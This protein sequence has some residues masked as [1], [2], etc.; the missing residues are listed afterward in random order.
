MR[1]FFICAWAALLANTNA[2]SEP[3]VQRQLILGGEI[4]PSGSKTYVVGL[5]PTVNGNSLCGG[6]LVSPTHVLTASHCVTQDI[7]W[8]SIG[9]HY[10]N[11]TQDGE[12][13]RVISIMNHPSYFSEKERYSSDFAM[14]ELEKPSRFKP[15]KLAAAD[16]SDFTAGKWT[17]TMGW[18]MDAEVNGTYSHE[19]QR[20]DL[21]LVGDQECAKQT[22]IDSTMVCAGGV[23]NRDSCY[24]DSGGPLIL[25]GGNS[26]EDVVIGVVSWGKDD[27]CG[28][29]GYPGIYS[30][31]SSV[32][33]WI[34]SI[35]EGNGTCLG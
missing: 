30:R 27:T 12:Q 2:F 13:I 5:R 25:D 11:G 17:V 31:V 32:R 3:P 22:L 16:D 15:V 4:V 14:L 21:Q 19:L 1:S 33:S 10:R 26:T 29:E 24:G 7:R 34:D 6:M 9:S 35:T 20:V 8:A 28:R 23:L 18:G